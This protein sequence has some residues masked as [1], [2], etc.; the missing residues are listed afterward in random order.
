VFSPYCGLVADDL[1]SMIVSGCIAIIYRF[2]IEKRM[3]LAGTYIEVGNSHLYLIIFQNMA[4]NRISVQIPI[5]FENSSC[6]GNLIE[7]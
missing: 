6:E 4:Q 5:T 7:V 2:K 3:V 1:C